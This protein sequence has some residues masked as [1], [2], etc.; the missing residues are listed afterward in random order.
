MM[1][2]SGELKATA[3]NVQRIDPS[4]KS[5]VDEVDI[6]I[7]PFVSFLKQTADRQIGIPNS[8]HS[9]SMQLIMRRL[10]LITDKLHMPV[11]LTG[12]TGTGK[13]TIA[14]MY[15]RMTG[16]PSESFH[17]FVCGEFDVADLNTIKSQLFGYAK[18]A[19]T[20]VDKEHK[21]V[22]EMADGGTVFLDEI[23]DIP[24]ARL[25]R[26]TLK[27]H[28]P[29]N[30]GDI[31]QILDQLA[32]QAI[33][34]SPH[35]ITVA[36]VEDCLAALPEP[37]ADNPFVE[38]VRAVLEQWPTSSFA[39]K[40]AKGQKSIREIALGKLLSDRQYRKK[41]GDVNITEMAGF[42]GSI[43]RPSSRA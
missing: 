9:E 35:P 30:I 42:R 19:F 13:T 14:S 38:C 5:T 34:P 20:G 15:H 18:G 1:I 4:Q 39:D 36:E 22:L 32:I 6:G 3:L 23:G 7:Y 21:G 12:E 8:F 41:N 27:R 2:G 28:L 24:M 25:I 43:I 33:Q 17:H 31:Q 26:K 29:G 10:A 37:I 16:A 11:L 40:G